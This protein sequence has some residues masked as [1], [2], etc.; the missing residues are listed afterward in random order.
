MEDFKFRLQKVLDIRVK[1]EDENKI[2]Y[3]KAQ[4][5]K[6]AVEKELE[7][8]KLSYQKYSEAIHIEDGV[9][10]SIVSNYLSFVSNMIEKTD[11]ELHEKEV[12]VNEAR[13]ELLNSQIERKS[14]EKL[15]ENKYKLHKKEVDHKEQAINDEF[16]MYS[17]FRNVVQ[18]L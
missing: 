7:D 18:S 4:S 6:R 9:E 5:E 15:K 13:L 2:K 16:G 10:R 3:S 11:S 14:I 12:L 17:Y 1:N 8:L